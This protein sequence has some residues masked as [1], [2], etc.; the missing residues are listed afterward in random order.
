MKDYKVTSIEPTYLANLWVVNYIKPNG[1]ADFESI[2][3]LDTNEAFILFR[4][5]MIKRGKAAKPSR[6]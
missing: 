6:P 5:L 2:E 4:N 1:E 3:A